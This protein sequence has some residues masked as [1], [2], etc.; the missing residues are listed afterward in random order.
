[1]QDTVR[2][3][4]LTLLAHGEVIER[5]EVERP[6]AFKRADIGLTGLHVLLEHDSEVFLL[7]V[8]DTFVA[9]PMIEQPCGWLADGVEQKLVEPHHGKVRLWE[10]FAE[11]RD[12]DR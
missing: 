7:E 10:D 11:K 12:A 5:E 2:I 8:G 6:G 1:M 3:N 4:D 9:Q